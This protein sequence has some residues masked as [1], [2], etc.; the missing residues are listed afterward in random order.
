MGYEVLTPAL[1]GVAFLW[2]SVQ[3]K[4]G[5]NWRQFFFYLGLVEFCLSIGF[6]MTDAELLRAGAI[7]IHFLILLFFMF[8][9]LFFNV[10]ELW[11]K[12]R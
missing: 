11:S 6:S 8:I 12:S 3:N 4:T 2:L 7:L 9:N 10:G 1:F 5:E